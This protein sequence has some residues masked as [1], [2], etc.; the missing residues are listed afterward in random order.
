MV[1]ITD[2][3]HSP[4]FGGFLSDRLAAAISLSDADPQFCCATRPT[5]TTLREPLPSRASTAKASPTSSAIARCG[6]SNALHPWKKSITHVSSDV[7]RVECHERYGY[8]QCPVT[9]ALGDRVNLFLTSVQE[10]TK[11]AAHG[12]VQDTWPNRRHSNNS[13]HDFGLFKGGKETKDIY[14]RKSALQFESISN[15]FG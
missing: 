2:A 13:L 15:S 3:F 9:L 5:V 4:G 11:N 10:A 7:A 8:V 14:E 12:W 6:P 1:V